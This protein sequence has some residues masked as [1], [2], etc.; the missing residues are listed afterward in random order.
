MSEDGTKKHRRFLTN[1]EGLLVFRDWL[2]EENCQVVAL[3]SI[4]IYW[5]TIN[6]ILE[7]TV[8]VIVANAYKI[9]TLTTLPQ[10]PDGACIRF[11]RLFVAL[12][13]VSCY[14]LMP[15][16]RHQDRLHSNHGAS[17]QLLLKPLK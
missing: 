16:Q 2:I 11:L 9:K 14:A 15:L 4:G 3:E 13:F 7:G 17:R 5:I 1:T 8:K 6:T 10:M 12:A